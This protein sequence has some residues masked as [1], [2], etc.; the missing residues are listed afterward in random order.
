M[1]QIEVA[2]D[3]DANGIV[4][5]T[6]KDVATG[7]EQKITISNSSGLSKDE[8]DRMVKDAEGHAAEDKARRDVIDARN[9]ADSLAYSVEK[10]IGENRDRLPAVDVERVESAIAAVR[11]AVKG[12]NLEAIRTASADLQKASHSIAEQLYKQHGQAADQSDGPKAAEH[13]EVVDG[14]EVVA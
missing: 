1:P 10:T 8:V 6:A 4:N 3:I 12:D 9:Q 2:F 14:R 7:K 5:V 11:E 13:D